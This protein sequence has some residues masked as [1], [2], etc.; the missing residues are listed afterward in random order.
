M[1]PPE[2]LLKSWHKFDQYPMETLTKVWFYHQAKGNKQRELGLIKEHHA[3][4]GISGN[5]FDLVIMLLDQF[6]QDGVEAYPI[7]NDLFTENAHVAVLALDE[8]GNRYLCDLGD[9]WIIPVLIEGNHE[10]YSNKIH[11]GFFPAAKIRV[12]PGKEDVVIHYHRPNGKISR[13]RFNLLPLQWDEFMRAAEFS[14]NLLKPHPL[15]E[16]RVSSNEGIS[17]WEFYNWESYLS[18]DEGLTREE[19]C[20]STDQWV[21][22]IYQMTGYDQ[23]FLYEA[24]NWYKSH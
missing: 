12:E 16:C 7:G 20:Q 4:Y 6:K 17:H 11:S 23:D 8:H 18:T 15:L 13:Q 1:R 5:C 22:R 19:P 14:Q 10:S 3:A 9:Q 24:L 21:G 2:Y